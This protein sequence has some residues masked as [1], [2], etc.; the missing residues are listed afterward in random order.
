MKK[1]YTYLLATIILSNTIHAQ[2]IGFSKKAHIISAGIEQNGFTRLFNLG[3]P[4]HAKY[5]YFLTDLFSAGFKAGYYRFSINQFINTAQNIQ[6]Y[7]YTDIHT[8]LFSQFHFLNI[9]KKKDKKFDIYLG[10]NIGVDFPSF[11][12]SSSVSYFSNPQFNSSLYLGTRVLFFNK[13]GAFLELGYNNVLN[14]YSSFNNYYVY[15]YS[16]GVL[17]KF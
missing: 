7:N 16:L 4:I 9:A 5:E 3:T 10:T 12:T 6:T 11:Y 15:Y 2:V 1:I 13:I 8:G 14:N 17:Y